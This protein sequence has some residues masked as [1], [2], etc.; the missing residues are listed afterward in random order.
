MEHLFYSATSSNAS[1]VSIAFHSSVLFMDWTQQSEIMPFQSPLTPWLGFDH[2]S[3]DG[4]PLS[5]IQDYPSHYGWEPGMIWQ[6]NLHEA[7]LCLKNLDCETAAS[8]VAAM[9]QSWLYLGLLESVLRKHVQVSYL[10]R[11]DGAGKRH[12][13]TQNLH[14]CLQAWVFKTRL[15]DERVKLEA[16]RQALKTMAYVHS[17][18]ERLNSW[19]NPN[20]SYFYKKV[21]ET[22][23][24]FTQLLVTI[25]PS[26]V[27]LAEIIDSARIRAM[28]SSTL[29]SL[30]LAW[31]YPQQVRDYRECLLIK[32]G[33]CPFTIQMVLFN[34]SESTVDWLAY[35]PAKGDPDLHSN[36]S[37]IE[38][39][40]NNIDKTNYKVSHDSKL[41]PGGCPNVRPQIPDVIGI[42]GENEDSIPVFSIEDRKD[43]VKLSMTSRAMKSPD[44]ED[45][46]AVS[47]V[48]V[49]G[50]GS[51]AEIGIPECQVRRLLRLGREV[52]QKPNPR[53]WIDSLCI[54]AAKDARAKAIILMAD[55]YSNA[56]TVLVVDQR[57]REQKLSDSIQDLYCTIFTSAWMQRLWTYQEACLAQTLIFELAENDFYTLRFPRPGESIG[58]TMIWRAFGAQLTRLR[59][60]RDSR[61]NLG[62]VSRALNWR[63]T[64][65][66]ID[67][68]AAVAGLVQ[69][70]SS[71]LGEIL[72]T[73]VQVERM[74]IFLKAVRWLPRNILFLPGSKVEISSFRWAPCTFMNRSEVTLSTDPNE[75]TAECTVHGLKGTW[76]TISLDHNLTGAREGGP[77]IRY[78][79]SDW[80][81]VSRSKAYVFRIYCNEYWPE[82]SSPAHYNA[83]LLNCELMATGSSV[84]GEGAW[85]RGLAVMKHDEENTWLID[86]PGVTV[87]GYVGQVSVEKMRMDEALQYMPS[88]M[89]AMPDE[90]ICFGDIGQARLC[91]R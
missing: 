35:R 40:R 50:L 77:S 17:W 47:H 3:D 79:G 74:R 89:F 38:C 49:D 81:K 56:S 15:A 18:V 8:A 36:C 69:L 2:I 12:I 16:H 71:A 52:T 68:L 85:V 73:E 44:P 48:W 91:I 7:H 57:I 51:T 32:N 78:V 75:Q 21:E 23:P 67:E 42:L 86:E 72:K 66:H 65:R 90:G 70:R 11:A 45:Y 84:I 87:C 63:S 34:L 4:L 31:S 6:G 27:R 26:I 59:I 64:K 82:P 83:V 24:K 13:F 80:T 76:L 41:C 43:G 30:G 88:L 62:S 58:K 28:P 9:L 14:A 29:L 5:E 33:W 19:T 39:L 22:Y 55:T 60:D 54:P 25:L 61:S 46:I 1:D 53:L 20:N 10:V 37:G